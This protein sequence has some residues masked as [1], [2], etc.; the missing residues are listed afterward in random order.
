MLD[1]QYFLRLTSHAKAFSDKLE[2]MKSGPLSGEVVHEL[3][4]GRLQVV[5]LVHRDMEEDRGAEGV[6]Q[7]HAEGNRRDPATGVKVSEANLS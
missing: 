3:E 2:V 6:Q 1:F 7:L 5:R 4:V